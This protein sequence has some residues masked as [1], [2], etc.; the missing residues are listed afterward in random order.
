[1]KNSLRCL[2]VALAVSFSGA[3]AFAQQGK[4][5]D[6]LETGEKAAKGVFKPEDKGGDAALQAAEDDERAK[7]V[8]EKEKQLSE[9]RQRQIREMR[10]ILDKNP[11]YKNK[12][13]LLFRIAEKEW[14]EAKYRYFLQRK[15]YDK[16]YEA[17]LNGTL[18][19][20]PE[21]PQPD[22]SKALEEYKKLLKEFPN[23]ARL[24]E[25]MFY[26]GRGLTQ[27]EKKKEG[28]S[29]M[30]RLT[31]E[32]PKSKYVTQ[33][34]LAVAEYYFEN[35]LLFAAKTNYLKVLEDEKSNQYPYALY[36]LG[37]VHYNLKEYRESIQAFQKVVDLQKGADKRKVYL[38]QQAYSALDLAYAEVDDGWKEARD[39]FRKVGGDELAAE[40]LEKIAKIYNKQDKT[41]DEVAVYEYLISQNKEGKKVP[42]YADYIVAAYKKLENLEKADEVINR[43]VQVF[44][45]K[46]SWYTV[47]KG[48]EEAM[49][50]SNQFRTEQLDW[51]IGQYHTKAQE[52][53]KL[54]NLEKADAY[55]KKAA[56]Y[57]EMYIAAFPDAKDLYEKEFFLAEIYFFQT[58]EWDKAITHYKGV[59]TRDAKGKYSLDAAY[60]VILAAEEK[61]ADAGLIARPERESD[62]KKGK[63][64]VDGPDVT[65]VEKKD[66][67]EF[68]PIPEAPLHETETAFVKACED[69]VTLYPKDKEV[70]FVSF[71]A[72]EIY[73]NKGHYGEGIKRLEVIMEHHP[74]HKFAGHAAATLFDSNYR[75]RRWDQMERWGRYML[76]RKNFI[77]LNKQQLENVIAI[78]INNYATELAERGK[79]ENNPELLDKAVAE[80][81]RFV[82]EYPKHE[83][84]GIALFNAAAIQEKA[85][86][87]TEAVDLYESVIKRY[88]GSSQAIEAHFVLGALYESQTAFETAATYFEKMANIKL[89]AGKGKRGQKGRDAAPADP[90]AAKAEAEERSQI[91][92]ALYNAGA[93]RMAL[94]QTD[95]AITI[96]EKYIALFPDRDD[97]SDVHLR[98]AELQETKKDW[99]KAL[100]VY[101]GWLKTY[102][103]TQGKLVPEVYLRRAKVFQ[104]RSDKDA[105]KDASRE[106]DLA[107]KAYKRLPAAEQEDKRA[108]RAAAE[109]RF[110]EGEYVYGDFQAVKVAFPDSVLRKSLTKKAELLEKASTI[111]FEVLDFK[112]HDISAGA[113][114]RIGESFNVF[115]QSLFDLPIPEELTEDEKVVYRAELDDRAAPLAEKAIEASR[116]ALQLAHNNHVYNEWSRRSAALLVKLSPD[117]FP[118]LEDASVN[119][120]W[121][122]PAMFSTTFVEDPSVKLEAPKPA[123]PASTTATQAQPA[124]GAPAPA[125]ASAAAAPADK[126]PA[127]KPAAAPAGKEAQ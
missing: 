124:A 46:S 14:E 94:E 19:A 63:G 38:T 21:E 66:D 58:K 36:K 82:N 72:A 55:Y 65:F 61:M 108:R 106:L 40:N 9:V 47:N 10:A 86:K 16:Q 67:K 90:E 85:E 126:T 27:A 70:P 7:F 5:A 59:Y 76:Q 29:Y 110:L 69:Y 57:Y 89:D 118:I 15:D 62:K 68:K 75:L 43:F 99:G 114:Y 105:R 102:A 79:K 23:Y 39:Y 45:P 127:E 41:D 35:D 12:A 84:A 49:T 125:P 83:K 116:R 109:A 1:M 117:S 42:E 71:R 24:D 51:L 80:M 101:D 115:A 74:S 48:D 73:I 93:I 22:Y 52:L 87:T 13:D 78:S 18:K 8:A 11:L 37:Y 50:R 44:D 88:P 6:A 98:I 20:K 95:A 54:K 92:D 3:P 25:V 31:K 81:L 28:A 64:K 17:F 2:T 103:K 119:T 122:V 33:A 112:A 26:L 104:A 111:F 60:A 100:K 121:P 96:F 4:Q 30:L 107:V 123:A 113:L 120:E 53:E 56:G 32:Y 91:A 97:T 77:V 34:Y